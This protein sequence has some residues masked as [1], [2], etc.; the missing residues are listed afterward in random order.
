MIPK[1]RSQSAR[2]EYIN[3]CRRRRDIGD[4][5]APFPNG[6]FAVLESDCLAVKE[7]K[8]VQ[9]LGELLSPE[10]VTSHGEF[11]LPTDT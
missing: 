9:V 2:R 11:L 5:P 10:C 3:A 4:I 7:R 1:F 8:V 6:W